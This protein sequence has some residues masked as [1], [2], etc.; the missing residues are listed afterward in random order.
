[1]KVVNGMPLPDDAVVLDQGEVG[2]GGVPYV[3]WAVPLHRP[4]KEEAGAV[5]IQA[6]SAGAPTVGQG[7]ILTRRMLEQLLALGEGQ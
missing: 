3:I 6:S 4:W 7:V 1:M 5:I 2:A